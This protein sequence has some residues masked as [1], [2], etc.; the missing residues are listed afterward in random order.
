MARGPTLALQYLHF[1]R[2]TISPFSPQAPKLRRLMP[3]LTRTPPIITKSPPPPKKG[4]AANLHLHFDLATADAQGNHPDRLEVV[5]TDGTELKIDLESLPNVNA[6]L[7]R[8][9][10]HANTIRVKEEALQN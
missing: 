1:V 6:V 8:V 2:L 4:P 3:Y 10:R 5:Y 9:N 7:D